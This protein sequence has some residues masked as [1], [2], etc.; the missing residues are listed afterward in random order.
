MGNQPGD[1]D[2]RRLDD[3]S[4]QPP[5]GPNQGA[6][7]ASAVQPSAQETG[8]SAKEASRDSAERF[9]ALPYESQALA[10]LGFRNPE[11]HME[12]RALP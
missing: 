1:T 12:T 3:E 7:P 5:E 2:P 11:S 4:Q 6:P 9:T 8:N 10:Y